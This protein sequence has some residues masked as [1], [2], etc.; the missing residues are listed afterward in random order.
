MIKKHNENE[1][2]LEKQIQVLLM[3]YYLFYSWTINLNY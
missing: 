1:P 2:S 3:Y